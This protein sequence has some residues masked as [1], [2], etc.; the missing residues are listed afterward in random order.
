M[1]RQFIIGI[2]VAALVAGSG[3]TVIDP[4]W[5]S[6][7]ARADRI[8][9]TEGGFAGD[10]APAIDRAN[11]LRQDYYHAVSEQSTTRTLVGLSL[12]PLSASA[13]YLG[14]AAYRGPLQGIL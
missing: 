1:P 12:I 11:Q 9:Y 6:D 10:L 2:L 5:R 7:G 3:C 8:H 4:H 14:F 13:L